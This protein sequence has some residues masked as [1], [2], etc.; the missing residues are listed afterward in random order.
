MLSTDIAEVRSRV[1]VRARE[2][3]G[4]VPVGRSTV[5]LGPDCRR[6]VARKGAHI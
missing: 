4:R 3:E 6:Q 1:P 5:G 2:P